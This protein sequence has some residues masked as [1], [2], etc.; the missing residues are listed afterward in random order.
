MQRTT[1]DLRDL[2]KSLVSLSGAASIFGFSQLGR[3]LDIRTPI[4]SSNDAAHRLDSVTRAVTG[5]LA[6]RLP[7]TFA[8]ADIL[9][10]RLVDLIVDFVT[11]NPSG[12]LASSSPILAPVV[13]AIDP[14][15]A[16]FDRAFPGT[17]TEVRWLELRN[18][19]E[20]YFLVENAES[21]LGISPVE[22]TP[23]TELVERAYAL[24]MF[25]SI[26][27]VEGLGH[28]YGAQALGDTP[29]PRGLLTGP[30]SDA[31]RPGALLMLHAGIG[32]AFAESLLKPLTAQNAGASLPQVVSTFVV[33]CRE[34]SRPG[35]VGAAFESLGLFT[36]S[37]HPDLVA[38]VD[39]EL[40]RSAEDLLG[41][42][43]HGV[44]RA[45][46]FSARNFLPCAEI[47]W[48]GAPGAAP[49]ETGRLN[50]TAGLAWAVTLVNM[51]QPII[52]ERMLRRH[53]DVLSR[54][55]AFANGVESSIVMRSDTTPDADFIGSF[56]SYQP[57]LPTGLDV[58]WWSRLISGPCRQAILRDWPALAQAGHLDSV[59]QYRPPNDSQLQA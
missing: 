43:W 5:Q 34:N 59:F 3:L 11:L 22:Y 33:L 23:L 57:E 49:H 20:I 38:F 58:D 39:R 15:V 27:A 8:R 45:I 14:L 52:M 48:V 50:I 46:Y 41:Y 1:S 16:A 32:L 51:R 10:R 2:A 6:G 28:V 18:K 29:S 37:F 36:R 47:D 40:Q 19:L 31:V 54:T 55:P 30:E 9:Q 21:R 7:I 26:W 35:Y 24:G 56:C 12:F 25:L 42:F 4:R 13:S 17:E 53:G 44:G